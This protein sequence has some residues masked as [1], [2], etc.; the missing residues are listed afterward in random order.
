MM[1]VSKGVLTTH[2]RFALLNFITS[3]LKMDTEHFV[4]CDTHYALRMASFNDLHCNLY[5]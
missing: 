4:P 3:A 5:I 1:K 2:P